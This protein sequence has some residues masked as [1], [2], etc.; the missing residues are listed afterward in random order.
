MQYTW[1][2][3]TW[4]GLTESTHEITLAIG[5]LSVWWAPPLLLHNLRNRETTSEQCLAVFKCRRSSC[6]FSM[7]HKIILKPETKCENCTQSN[8]SE[9]G[10]HNP[11]SYLRQWDLHRSGEQNS[12]C[13]IAVHIAE[14]NGSVWRIKKRSSTKT[15]GSHLRHRHDQ[16]G[17]IRLRTT[18]PSNINPDLALYNF[19]LFQTWKSYSPGEI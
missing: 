13:K 6:I 9:V 5:K 17:R 14:K 3:S 11:Q 1:D 12:R 7:I 15:T 8:F 2:R 16:I 19:V 10:E 18:A 4:K